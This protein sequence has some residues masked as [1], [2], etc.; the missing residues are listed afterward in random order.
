MTIERE[1]FDGPIVFV[2]DECGSRD[3]THCQNF[4]GALAKFKMHGG[5]AVKDDDGWMHICR[6]CSE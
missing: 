6:E 3:E 5:Q 1:Y 4:G 2:C